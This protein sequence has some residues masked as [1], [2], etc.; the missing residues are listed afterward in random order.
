MNTVVVRSQA[1]LDSA[2]SAGARGIVVDAPRGSWITITGSARIA[3]VRGSSQI[4]KVYDSAEIA[5]VHGSA[6][7]V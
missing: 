5:K 2:V 6:Q 7:I 1:E 4:A 3:E